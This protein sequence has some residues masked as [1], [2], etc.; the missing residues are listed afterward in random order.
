MLVYGDVEHIES[1]AAVRASIRGLM[2]ACIEMQP[3]RQRHESL[4]Q[5][6]ILTGELVQALA[7]LEFGKKG[8]DDVSELQDAGAKL[9]LMQA[10]EVMR[11]WRDGFA[12]ILSFPEDWTAKL[13][14]LDSTDPVRMKR[15]EGYAFYALYPESYIEAASISK[16]TPKTVVIGIRSIGTGLA[17]LVSAALGA[18]PAYSLRPTGHPFERQVHVTPAFSKRI[19]ADP[20]TDF[21]IV[22]EGPGLSGSSFGCVGDWLQANGVAPDRLHFFPSHAGEPGPHASNTHLTRWRDRPR[23]IVSFDDLTLTAQDPKQ[24]LHTWAA[25]VVGVARSSWRDLSGGAWRAVR[26]R[27]PSLWPPSYMQREK[28]KFLMEAEGEAWHVKFAG[29]CGSDVDKARRGSLLSEAGF[30]P[31]I[32]GTCYGFIIEEWIIGTPLDNSDVGRRHLVDHLGRYLGFRARHL[33]ARNGGASIQKLCEMA[34]FNIAEAA[35]S[36]TAEKLRRAI[37]T[38]ERLAGRLRRVDTD[39]RLHPWEWLTS[40]TGRIIKTDALDHNAA[41]DLIGCQDIAWDVVGACV[42]F[43][44]SSKERDRLVGLVG[45]E[46]DC[47]LRDDVLKIFEACYLGFQIGLWSQAKASVDGAETAR[48]ERTIKRYLDRLPQLIDI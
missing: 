40:T 41:H 22:D 23:H 8:V 11:S 12:G 47:D 13:E 39:N 31:R 30:I 35:G 44:L 28:R 4:V 21:A 16:L 27:D 34:I 1:A 25:D 14:S 37:G 3:G 15:A 20:E 42:E 46:A 33:P 45:R 32:A 26:Y 29:L 36:D 24:R 38:P 5:A 18:E 17:A 43:E 7:D 2:M 6:F 48:I 10:R 9:L 19:L